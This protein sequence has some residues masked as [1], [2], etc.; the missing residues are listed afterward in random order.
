M[1]NLTLILI[2]LVIVFSI[3]AQDTTLPRGIC[4]IHLVSGKKIKN[5]Q[6]WAISHQTAEYLEE[7]SLHDLDIDKINFVRFDHCDYLFNDSNQLSRIDYDKLLLT[8]G[9]TLFCFIQK[10]TPLQ[11]HYKLS[12]TPYKHSIHAAYVKS[13][14]YANS[15]A[16]KLFEPNLSQTGDSTL[17]G[18]DYYALGK[19]DGRKEFKGNGSVAGGL[20]CGII[21]V[22]GW[23]V[24][25][26]TL[27]IPPN[28]HPSKSSLYASNKLYAQGYDKGAHNKKM[29]RTLCGFAAGLTLLLLI[30]L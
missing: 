9:D 14:S 1:K 19:S 27:A 4:S 5:V 18:V 23:V 6:L 13:Y 21:P 2:A 15:S 16:K 17:A 30:A 8:N 3:R 29:R 10:I 12:G 25:P 28:K 20:F 26:M 22:F 11:F 24:G 7:G